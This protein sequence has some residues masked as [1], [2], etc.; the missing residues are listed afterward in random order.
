MAAGRI[1]GLG[2][3]LLLWVEWGGA[4]AALHRSA[5]TERLNP[6]P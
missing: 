2:L 6:K 1:Q 3:T 5:S 4:S